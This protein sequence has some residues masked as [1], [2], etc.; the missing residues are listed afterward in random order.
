MEFRLENVHHCGAKVAIFHVSAP[1]KIALPSLPS[2][3]QNNHDLEPKVQNGAKKP[4]YSGT[5]LPPI[6]I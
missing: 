5:K 6:N 2:T 1:T 3:V 4:L